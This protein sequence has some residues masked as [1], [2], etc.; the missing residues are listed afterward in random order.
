MLILRKILYIINILLALALC[1]TYLSAY[2]PQNIFAK[3]SLL[4]YWYPFL[5][6]ANIVFIVIWLFLKP[7]HILLSLIVI[8]I[9]VDYVPRL[10]NFERPDKQGE[11]SILTY[12]VKEF[13]H[14][15]DNFYDAQQSLDL[16]DSILNYIGSTKANI[17][18]L[19]DYSINIK[20]KNSFHT[21][22]VDSLG[23][24][25]FYYAHIGSSTIN[26]CAI[27]T[28]Y[29][30]TNA[31]MIMPEDSN[32]Y[33]F[34]FADIKTPKRVIRVMNIHL[35]SYMLGP[36]EKSEYAKITK[37]K[38]SDTA[39]RHIVSKLLSANRKRAY[40]VKALMS[41]L[42]QSQRP[43]LLVGDFNDHPFSY[44]YSQTTKTLKDAFLS[45]GRG[46]GKT[47]NGIF[48]AYRIDYVLYD[49]D[50]FKAKTYQSAA[51]DF[52]D[53]YPVFVTLDLVTQ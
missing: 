47:Y 15:M 40:Q 24:N 23:Y 52:S 5:L 11:I 2:V 48:P 34:I 17:V 22:M 13:R 43:T 50:R 53:H 36:K 38:I 8:L 20:T 45:K 6:L 27:Y 25:H 19:Q 14:N 30:I 37:G 46:I 28:K 29:P 3:V 26:N 44:T 35:A 31:G 42:S 7:R 16:Q 9:R 1:L 39:S 49:K 12:N 32:N 33:E 10:V 4:G 21:K 51:L 41:N 18:C